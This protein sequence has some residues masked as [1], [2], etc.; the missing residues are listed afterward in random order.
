[1][2]FQ[3]YLELGAYHWDATSRHP[4][5]HVAF[6]AGRYQAILQAVGDWRDKSVLDIACGDCRLSALAL[7]AGARSVVGIDASSAGLDVGR[8]R[9]QE[10]A[11]ETL[12]RAQFS[13]ADA[14]QELQVD[15]GSFD[16]VLASEIIEHLK[17]PTALVR[18][19]ARVVAPAGVVVITTPYRLTERPLDPFHVR[20]Y[21]PG[22]LEALVYEHFAESHVVL[23]HPVWVTGLFALGRRFRVPRLVINI[24][25]IC[26]HNPFLCW[27]TGAYAGQITLI[28]SRS[29]QVQGKMSLAARNGVA[30]TVERSAGQHVSKQDTS[31]QEN[32]Q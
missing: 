17:E 4:W 6:T 13:I 29:R 28:A 11:P 31:A 21:Y 32:A 22:E 8:K 27:P 15:D 18:Q 1:M 19:M 7:A 26:G 9:W 12:R 16:I 20:E 25:S 24:L 23:T 2:D 5:R 10:E 14:S 3:K 30:Q